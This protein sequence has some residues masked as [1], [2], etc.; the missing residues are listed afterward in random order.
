MDLFSSTISVGLPYG[1]IMRKLD[2]GEEIEFSKAI[3]RQR[4]TAIIRM[5]AAHLRDSD[6]EGLEMSDSTYR[7]ILGYCA[8]SRQQSMVCVDYYIARAADVSYVHLGYTVDVVE[9]ND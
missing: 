2:S 5:Y 1:R 7:R 9:V 6:E 8:A 3:R 4:D